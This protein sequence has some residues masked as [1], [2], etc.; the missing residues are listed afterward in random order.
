MCYSEGTKLFALNNIIL[1]RWTPI[2]R[3]IIDF[4]VG[5]LFGGLVGATLGLLLAPRSGLDTRQL[6]RERI[7][8][9]VEEAKQAA[10]E[11]RLEL[12]ARLAAAKRPPAT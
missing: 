7:N 6:L 10:A 11:Q 12:E 2:M 1:R 4:V 3:K 9:I 8:E 5:L